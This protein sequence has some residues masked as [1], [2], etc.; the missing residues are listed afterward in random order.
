MPTAA[1]SSSLLPARST[2]SSSSSAVVDGIQR[3][4]ALG[5]AYNGQTQQV[6]PQHMGGIQ[7]AAD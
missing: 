7:A 5:M 3:A 1:A 2:N 6:R 4:A